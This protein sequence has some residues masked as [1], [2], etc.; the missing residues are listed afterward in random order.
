MSE[1]QLWILLQRNNMPAFEELYDRYARVLYRYCRN[2][3]DDTHL[4]EDCIQELF[5]RLW[6]KR[7]TLSATSSVRFYLLRS[8][9]RALFRKLQQQNKRNKFEQ[10]EPGM[11][12]EGIRSPEHG[13][14]LREEDARLQRILLEAINGLPINQRE[15]MYLRYYQGLTFDEIS[16]VT[17][18][19]KKSA[20]NLVF[21][22]LKTLRKKLGRLMGL[23]I[24]AS[25]FIKYW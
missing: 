11:M 7:A 4:I 2:F 23:L 24:A 8:V 14:I 1:E 6:E 19:Q 22:A 18:V 13:Y 17:G 16:S 10:G 25:F 3:S 9:R 5:T 15:M 20:Y 21:I 12:F